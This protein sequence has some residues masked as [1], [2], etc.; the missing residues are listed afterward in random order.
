MKTTG[1]RLYGKSDLRLEKFDL[2][3][4]KEDEI[5]ARVIA[6]S[7]CMSTLK[8]AKLGPEHKRVPDNVAENPV[9]IGHEFSGII[10]KV[11][12]KWKEK[13]QA[14][15]N[16]TLQPA[17]N[18]KGSMDSPGYSY[19]YCG[20]NATHIIIPPEVMELDCLIPYSAKGYYKAALAEPYSCVIGALRSMYR[21]DRVE[22]IHHMGIKDNGKMAIMGGCGPMGLAMIDYALSGEKKPAVLVVT[23]MDE[24]RLKR[25]ESFFAK[26]AVYHGIQLT[27]LNPAQIADMKKEVARLTENKGFDDALVMVPVKPLLEEAFSYLGFNGCLNFFAG[28]QDNS[29]SAQINYYDVH[30]LEKHVM[31]T[32]GGTV[33][34]MREAMELIDQDLM[35][36]ATLITHI[37]GIDAVSNAVLTLD[38]IP[39]GK[40]LIYNQ[41]R[42]PLFALEDIPLKKQENKL[43]KGLADILEENNGLWNQQAEDFLLENAEQI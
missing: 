25:A 12:D 2:P 41:I 21:A 7:I 31:G 9:L 35:D 16:F 42:L 18:Y 6:D 5:L 29:F 27:F 23:D 11:G 26:K 36:P 17:L 22:H 40:K 43:M 15:Q 1:V 28:P 4:I 10:L 39:G 30:Y 20:G 13:Y 24:E 14:G 34:D 32:T 38:Q 33:A 3:E 19:A 37:G 8:A